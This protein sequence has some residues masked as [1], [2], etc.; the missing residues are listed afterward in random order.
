MLA[1]CVAA[2]SDVLEIVT[3]ESIP[4]HGIRGGAAPQFPDRN[5][6]NSSR[7]YLDEAGDSY[8]QRNG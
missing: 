7:Q 2:G 5:R 6:H 1:R 8:R 4:R 3:P